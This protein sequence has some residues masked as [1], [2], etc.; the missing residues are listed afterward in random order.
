MVVRTPTLAIS[1]AALRELVS[2]CERAAPE[3]ACGLLGGTERGG[4]NVVTVYP[5][6]NLLHSR[7][8]FRIARA[9]VG[10]AEDAMRARGERL[11]GCFHS[12]PTAA[13]R[14]S[15][16]D[17]R[18][19]SRA[20]FWWVIYSLRTKTARAFLWDG[21]RFQAARLSLTR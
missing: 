9:A 14:P 1:R 11:C 19:A 12:H 3:E 16:Y 15:A 4:L 17:K 2:H 7:T 5:A 18:H 8:G 6:E 13:A 10:A 20:G 21:R